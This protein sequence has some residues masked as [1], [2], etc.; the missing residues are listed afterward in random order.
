MATLTDL[1]SAVKGGV[2]FSIAHIRATTFAAP[3]ILELT[4]ELEKSHE[5][6]ER[7]RGPR[8]ARCHCDGSA[9]H[10]RPRVEYA[11]LVDS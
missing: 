4:R 1:A 3:S 5:D 10:F 11:G 9:D 8:S 7:A 6:P 2:V